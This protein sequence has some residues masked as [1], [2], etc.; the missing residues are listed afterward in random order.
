LFQ[1]SLSH[2]GRSTYQAGVHHAMTRLKDKSNPVA[3]CGCAL[4]IE[5]LLAA[6]HTLD[7]RIAAFD[8][9]FAEARRNESARWLTSTS[10]HWRAQPICSYRGR[11]GVQTFARARNLAVWIEL[12]PQQ[13]TR[14]SKLRLFGIT[15]CARW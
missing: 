6:W 8:A 4:L 10:E 14:G 2:L 3:G 15:T 11:G 13:A 5:G 1:N 9:E 7:E 12:V